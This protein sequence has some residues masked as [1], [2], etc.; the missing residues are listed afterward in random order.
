LKHL[1]HDEIERLTG[2]LLKI[3]PRTNRASYY[4]VAEP[5]YGK[6]FGKSSLGINHIARV[7]RPSPF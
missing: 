5:K 3:H 7:Q 2:T 6:S 4:A 1:P